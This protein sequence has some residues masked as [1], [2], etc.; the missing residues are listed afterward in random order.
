MIDLVILNVFGYFIAF[1]LLNPI[2]FFIYISIMWSLIAI[3][4]HFYEVYRYTKVTQIFSLL[5]YQFIFLLFTLFAFV[6]FFREVHIRVGLILEYFLAVG[7]LISFVKFI[8]Y[9]TIML[10]RGGQKGNIRRVVVIG[11][12]KKAT[13]LINVFHEKKEFGYNFVKQFSVYDATFNMEDFFSFCVEQ[14]ID[15]I[16]CSVAEL[17]NKH[18]N[19]IIQFADNNLKTIKFL[20][21]NKNI[22]TK[23]LK[24][25]YYDYLPILSLRDIPLEHSVNAFVKRVFDILFS[26]FI[27]VFVLSW[28]TPLMA[29]L[30]RLESKGPTFFRQSRNGLDNAEFGCYKFRSMTVNSDSDKKSA[31]RNDA[32]VTKMGNFM[33]KTSIDELPQF[34]NVFLGHMS[35]VGPRP[36]M[37]SHTELYA[38][39]I[40][41]YMVRHFVKPGITGLAQIKGYRGQI[42]TESDI[43]NRVKLD[44]FY[45]ENW[46]IFLDIKIVVK[47]VL[48]AVRGEEKAY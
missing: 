47:T 46:N 11:K 12:S 5:F 14:H 10:Y 44:I 8:T 41:K 45:I 7:L 9:Y 37:L 13:Q 17:K 16:Y 36:H 29:L 35:V 3:R 15:E 26:S 18:F 4:L 27:I 33:R 22:Y 28:L 34:F 31:T 19:E 43:V 42:E 48:N 38:N 40:D 20:P 39:K 6:G 25:E 2:I 24:F 21:D 32:R 23:K 1:K 30:I